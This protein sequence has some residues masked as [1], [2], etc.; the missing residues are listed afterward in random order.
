MKVQKIMK[1]L[2]SSL[3]DN[4]VTDLINK[5]IYQSVINLYK[6]RLT[7]IVASPI[8]SIVKD[9]LNPA[10]AREQIQIIKRYVGEICGKKMLEIGCGFGVFVAVA[11]EER[12]ESFGVEQDRYSL[13]I[14]KRILNSYG[15]DNNV[16]KEESGESLSFRDES[17]DI[18]YLNNVIEHVKEVDKV[19]KESIRVTKSGGYIICVTPNYGSFFEGHYGLLWIPYLSKPLAKL[20][21]QLCG[22]DSKFINNLNFIT[23]KSLRKLLLKNHNVNIVSWGIDLWKERMDTLEFSEWAELWRLK[24]VLKTAQKLRLI[25]IVKVICQIIKAYNPLILTIRKV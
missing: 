8:E 25:K 15:I 16:V 14:C 20:Y 22:R 7:N 6:K 18:V 2:S 24:Y 17:F 4:T 23:M 1:I 21:V 5:E 10:R 9:T 11:R 3:Q 19:L 12:I 13:E